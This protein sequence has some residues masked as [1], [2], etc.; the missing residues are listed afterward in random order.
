[1]S[2]IVLYVFDSCQV[3]AIETLEPVTRG[4]NV[5]IKHRLAAIRTVLQFGTATPGWNALNELEHLSSEAGD[6]VPY[7]T[8]ALSNPSER[9]RGRAATILGRMGVSAI[10]AV[11]ALRLRLSDDWFNVREAATNAI[12][13]IEA[14]KLQ[15]DS[16]QGT[17]RTDP[18]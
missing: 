2:L 6:L 12:R 17:G 3:A 13:A 16:P 10:G 14:T 11:P 9:V 15:V 4:R 18:R 8:V 7:L 1:M 5:A